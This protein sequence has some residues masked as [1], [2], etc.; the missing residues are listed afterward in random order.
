MRKESES[1]ET[2]TNI[3]WILQ[4]EEVVCAKIHTLPLNRLA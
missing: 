2:F 1:H 4:L 3:R